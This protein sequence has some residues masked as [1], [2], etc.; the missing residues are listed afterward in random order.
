MDTR[1]YANGTFLTVGMPWSTYVSGAALC[2]DG[3]VRKLK[4]IAAT[5]DTF[6]SVPA[7]VV[8]NGR[9]VAGYVTVE[10]LAGYSTE[11]ADDPAVVKFVSYTYRKNGA[12]L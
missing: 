3:K 8:V 11:T 2:S 10:T 5:A 9:T 4:R 1:H 12:L 7:S 6:F